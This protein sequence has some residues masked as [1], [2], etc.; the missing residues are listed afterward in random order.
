MERNLAQR[1]GVTTGRVKLLA[2]ERAQANFPDQGEAPQPAPGLVKVIQSEGRQ[3]GGRGDHRAVPG[4]RFGRPARK[5]RLKFGKVINEVVRYPPHCLVRRVRPGRLPFDRNFEWD[6]VPARPCHSQLKDV[7]HHVGHHIGGVP[8]VDRRPSI[9]HD[10]DIASGDRQ[11]DALRLIRRRLSRRAPGQRHPCEVPKGDY[12]WLMFKRPRA[13]KWIDG[14]LRCSF[15]GKAK[16]E[17]GK[18]IA[19]PGVY[20]CNECVGLCGEII[21]KEQRPA[22]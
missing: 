14:S 3:I 5:P 19:G 7:V 2:A 9:G 1:P 15:C 12:A 13:P 10:V 17:V 21:E 22:R 16:S 8:I 11:I 4:V 18:L 20:I 6:A